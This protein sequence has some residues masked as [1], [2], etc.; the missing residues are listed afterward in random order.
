MNN[1]AIKYKIKRRISEKKDILINLLSNRGRYLI[2]SPT[3]TG[4][5]YTLLS[6]DDGIFRILAEKYPNR[7]FIIACPNRIQNEQNKKSYNVFALIGG[8]KYDITKRICSMVYEKAEDIIEEYMRASDRDFSIIIDESH[9][10]M[11]AEDYRKEAIIALD[12]LSDMA[13]S[14]A[15]LTATAETLLDYYKYDKILKF[16]LMNPQDANNLEKLYIVPTSDI[17]TSLAH[18]IK[19]INMKGKQVLVI[20]DSK[21]SI[22]EFETLLSKQGL[23]I[24]TVTKENKKNNEVYDSIIKY[25]LIPDGYD[26]VISTSAME[27]GTNIYNENI[28]MIL[29]VPRRDR[30][31]PER[32]EQSFAR[33]R[34]K[35]EYAV[36]LMKNYEDAKDEK[37]VEKE[38]ISKSLRFELER[39]VKDMSEILDVLIKQGNS[40][41]EA[42]NLISGHL[43]IKKLDG[44]T[45][46]K[47][48]LEVDTEKCK[49]KINEK[50]FIV[51]VCNMYYSQLVDKKSM[52]LECLNK[53]IK[54]DKIIYSDTYTRC[55]EKDVEE[56]KE[57]KESTE[58]IKEEL[59]NKARNIITSF[60]SDDIL[61]EQFVT[62]PETLEVISLSKDMEEKFEFLKKEKKELK[63]LKDMIKKD[64]PFNV[65]MDIYKLSDK[66]K[67]M[68]EKST[69]YLYIKSNQ[70]IPLGVQDGL[71][72]R[73]EYGLIRMVI[74]P[75]CKKQGR[76]TEKII[77]D[78]IE[79]LIQYKEFNKIKAYEKYLKSKADY[80]ANKSDKT[81]KEKEKRFEPIKDYIIGRISLI[82]KLSYSK[83]DIRVSSLKKSFI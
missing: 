24:G 5:T 55:D 3:D 82:Y 21:E 13:Y 38:I 19:A 29:V 62:A 36:L 2:I 67:S 11:Y 12:K 39:T 60:A 83:D 49:V 76:I 41:E 16:E 45:V 70:M 37:I 75:V 63:Q 34:V 52:F 22:S 72:M 40:K 43:N 56:L 6:E 48:L 65:V 31:N 71:N 26:C 46:G 32:A 14:V 4:K 33:I 73:Y 44:T 42:C 7:N 51:R 47:G 57:I 18:Q 79:D 80:K 10:L 81:L 28:V 58:N 50:A 8:E 9:Q 20:I 17:K 30:F 74:D 53:H 27:C 25:G 69:E 59:K 35:N 68:K 64:I 15:H 66:P 1:G 54:A 23:N 61:L 78:L 77:E